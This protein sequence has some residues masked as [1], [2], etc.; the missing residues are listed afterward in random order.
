[1][2]LHLAGP[3]LPGIGNSAVIMPLSS[4]N[5]AS[6]ENE[7]DRS[8]PFSREVDEAQANMSGSSDV[9]TERLGSNEAGLGGD[10]GIVGGSRSGV[11]QADG[12][13]LLDNVF[14][15]ELKRARVE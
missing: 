9:E 7:I 2:N 6:G 3:I 5:D 11:E 1:M 12:N 14:E 15:P 8:V 10:I 13:V 4:A